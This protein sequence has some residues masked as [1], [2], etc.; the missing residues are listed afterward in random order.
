MFKHFHLQPYNTFGFQITCNEFVAITS[1]EEFK[2][3]LNNQAFNG[4]KLV[5]GGG[6]NVLFTKDFDGTIIWNQIKGI[7]KVKENNKH[8]WLKVGAGEVWHQFVMYCVNNNYG[9]VENLSLIPGYV[10]AAPMQNIGA[11]GVEI[12]DVCESVEYISFETGESHILAANE[13]NFGYRESIFKHE[14]KDKVFITHVTFKLNKTHALNTQYGAIEQ[15]LTTKGIKSPTIKDVSEAVIAIRSSKLPDPKQIG[16]AG[17]FFKN[18][19]IS[20]IQAEKLRETHPNIAMYPAP[21]GVKVAAGWLIE[22]AGWKGYTKGPIGVHKKQALV[23]VNYGHG[24]GNEILTLSKNIQED[25]F[26]KFGVRLER[27]VNVIN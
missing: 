12:K 22:N 6:S 16:N 15:E 26:Q 18:P 23:L 21:D 14:L 10:G 4:K 19:V 13:C 17:S 20:T 7:E 8:I 1:V 9:G 3:N 11:Y 2:D 24:S 27:E 5:L 25:V